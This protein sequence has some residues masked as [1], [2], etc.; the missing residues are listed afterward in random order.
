M[1]NLLIVITALLIFASCNNKPIEVQ[2]P[3]KA[4]TLQLQ[5]LAKEDT[6]VYKVVE[7]DDT[8]YIITTT[9]HKVVKKLHNYSGAIDVL[10]IIAFCLFW[11]GLFIGLFKK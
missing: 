9:D 11:I 7:L 8:L 2:N 3:D 6:M 4:T 1:K 5:K 10:L